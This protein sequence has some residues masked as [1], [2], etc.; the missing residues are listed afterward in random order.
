M[1]AFNDSFGAEENLRVEQSVV[2][3]PTHADENGFSC[4]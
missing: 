2:I 3:G 1:T 4:N